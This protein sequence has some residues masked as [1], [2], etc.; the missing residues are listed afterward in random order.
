[1]VLL[2]ED[3]RMP[4]AVLARRLGVSRT[5]IQARLD[6]RN[7]PEPGQGWKVDRGAQRD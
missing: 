5:T 6:R 2:A 7:V 3:A 4:T 1:M